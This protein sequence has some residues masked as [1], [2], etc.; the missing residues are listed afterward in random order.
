MKKAP[1]LDMT[2][3]PSHFGGAHLALTIP[4]TSM[5]P[6]PDLHP[7]FYEAVPSKRLATWMIDTV[8]ITG[9][10]LLIIPFTAFTGIFFSLSLC[11]GQLLLPRCD[12]R[13]RVGHLGH[14]LYVDR[15]THP[16]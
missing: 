5:T 10:A 12:A 3:L 13:A 8:A 14:A 4:E 1:E 6:D 7:E 15:A 9:M 2:L 11:G 16:P